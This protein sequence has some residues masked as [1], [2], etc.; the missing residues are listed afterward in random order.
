[1][2]VISGHVEGKPERKRKEHQVRTVSAYQTAYIRMGRDLLMRFFVRG[3]GFCFF[4]SP[5]SGA[6]YSG[7]TAFIKNNSWPPEGSKQPGATYSPLVGGNV[8]D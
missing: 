4:I 7:N 8:G 2:K 3:S 5:S 1:M 6:P